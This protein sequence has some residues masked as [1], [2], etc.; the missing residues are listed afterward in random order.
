MVFMAYF[1]IDHSIAAKQATSPAD[2]VNKLV[3]DFSLPSSGETLAFAEGIFSRVP[4]KQSSGLNVLVEFCLQ[5]TCDSYITCYLMLCCSIPFTYCVYNLFDNLFFLVGHVL[6]YNFLLFCL[7]FIRSKREKLQCWQESKRH[8]HCLM[9]MTKMMLKIKDV[10]VIS[11][12]QKIERDILEGKMNIKKM[13]MMKRY[14]IWNGIYSVSV[15]LSGLS[16]L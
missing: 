7:S 9:L 3:I 4:R 6:L 13:K 1:Y 8:M 5:L 14:D 2:V 15:L 11:K 10:A 12:K 16:F